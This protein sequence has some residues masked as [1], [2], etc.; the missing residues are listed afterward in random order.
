MTEAQAAGDLKNIIEKFYLLVTGPDGSRRP[1]VDFAVYLKLNI[2]VSKTLMEDVDDWDEDD[3]R[4]TARADWAEDCERNGIPLS[5][6]CATPICASQ[7]CLNRR[8]FAAGRVGQEHVCEC[9]VPACG[10]LG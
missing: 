8:A 10:P 3:E 5:V 2:R 1:H 4:D 9:D 6:S 7:T